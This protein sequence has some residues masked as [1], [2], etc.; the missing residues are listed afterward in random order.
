[1]RDGSLDFRKGQPLEEQTVSEENID[2]HHI[3]PRSWCQ[4]PAN[5]IP[6]GFFNSIVNKTA[7]DAKTNRIVGGNEPSRYLP[8]LERIGEMTSDRM[9][10]ILETHRIPVLE[11][12]GDDFYGFFEARSERL[13]QSIESAMGK[14]IEGRERLLRNIEARN[15]R[16]AVS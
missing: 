7:I 3:F 10:E 15:T 14:G 1:M 13:L 6:A 2:I 16:V 5:S 8:R 11:L 9:D 12:R 4:K